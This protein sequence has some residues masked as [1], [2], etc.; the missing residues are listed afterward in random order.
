MSNEYESSESKTESLTNQLL[1]DVLKEM[2]DINIKLTLTTQ[3]SIDNNNAIVK[4]NEI[5]NDCPILNFKKGFKFLG[6]KLSFI[7]AVAG[8]IGS[9][10]FWIIKHF[11]EQ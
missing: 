4:I 9:F 11:S 10:A 2:K 8:F 6:L 7:L 5:Q 1:R 3:T